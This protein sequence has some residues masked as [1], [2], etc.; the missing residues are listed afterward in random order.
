MTMK[1]NRPDFFELCLLVTR[2]FNIVL[3]VIH[4][5]I[6]CMV[7]SEKKKSCCRYVLIIFIN[8]WDTRSIESHKKNDNEFFPFSS[9]MKFGSYT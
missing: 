1:V 6:V 4:F 3:Y 8:Y 2:V 5:C 7:S 9:P